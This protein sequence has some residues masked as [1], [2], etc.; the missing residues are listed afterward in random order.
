MSGGALTVTVVG[1]GIAGLASAIA[2]ARAGWRT[3]VLESRTGETEVG[4]GV[5]TLRNGVAAL[6]A[7]GLGDELRGSLGYETVATGFRDTRGRPIL[8]IPDDIEEVRRAA[9]VFGFHR[10]QLHAALDRAARDHGVQVITGARVTSLTVGVPGGPRAT[11]S[12]RDPADGKALSTESD[13]VV[14]ADG[15]W[16]AVR[17]VLYPGVRPTYSGSTSWRAIVLDTGF[18]GR[19]TEYWGPGSEFGVMRVSDTE[20]YWYGYVRAPRGA[21]VADEHATACARFAGWAP[22]VVDLIARTDPAQLMRHDVHHL[23][24]GLPNYVRGRVVLVGDAAHAALPTMGQGTATAL[25]D[26]VALGELVAAPVAAGQG[27]AEALE[28]FDAERRPVCRNT[29]RQAA[30]IAKIGADLG[31]GWRQTVRNA[32]LRSVPARALIPAA[33]QV[34]GQQETR[35]S[36]PQP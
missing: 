22:E 12:W 35:V 28:R 23:R 36:G 8:A 18:D 11:A 13:L 2:F 7:L 34:T 16:S 1:G 14:G 21:V 15:M 3:T 19:L 10:Q 30:F 33:A 17:G 5:A 25:E 9:T 24:G 6:E 31:G 29:A 27:P 4:A 32:I 20:L 26:A